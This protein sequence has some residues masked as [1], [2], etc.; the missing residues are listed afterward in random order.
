MQQ[1]IQI[2]AGRF[3]GKLHGHVEMTPSRFSPGF[4]LCRFTRPEIMTVLIWDYNAAL[5]QRC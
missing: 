1:F 2:H 3:E 5:V 4:S